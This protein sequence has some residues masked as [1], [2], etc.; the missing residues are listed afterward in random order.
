MPGATFYAANLSDFYGR[1]RSRLCRLRRLAAAAL[2]SPAERAPRKDFLPSPVGS[3]R[4]IRPRRKRLPAAGT[5]PEQNRPRGWQV[6]PA[7]GHTGYQGE[8]VTEPR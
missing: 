1:P 4:R 6:L 2:R 3:V 8:V 7:L 5:T